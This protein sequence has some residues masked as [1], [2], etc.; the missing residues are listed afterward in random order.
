MWAGNGYGTMFVPRIGMEVIVDFLEGDP[1][2][3][4]VTGC[5]YNGVNKP[6]YAPPGPGPA[7]RSGIKT[8]SSK[9]G[10]GTNELY[11]ED[12]QGSEEVFLQAERNLQVKVKAARTESIGG[13]RNTRIGS[14]DSTKVDDY[15]T[16]N[17]GTSRS[18]RVKGYSMNL[19][20]DF[21]EF[22]S[23]GSYLMLHGQTTTTVSG[24]ERVD[25]AGTEIAALG[26]SKI[27]LQ[28]GGS[29]IVLDSS[30][31]K[32]SGAMVSINSGG[33]PLQTGT[34][35]YSVPDNDAAGAHGTRDGS[36]TDP[37]QQLQAKALINAAQSNQALCAECQ[38]ARAAYQALMA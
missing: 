23:K 26:Y 4:I 18:V 22:G 21:S 32:I 2:Q 14:Y 16:L 20:D 10:G 8:L 30:G 29:F 1:D 35:S 34:I 25:I 19:A 38:A 31:V 17:V 3:P 12:K 33:A 5:V 24:S 37:I 11:F 28:A 7:T 13:A 15:Q 6:P 27:S 9:G 36:V